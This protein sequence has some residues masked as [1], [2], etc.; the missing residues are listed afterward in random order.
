V[1]VVNAATAVEK[2]VFETSC[3]RELVDFVDPKE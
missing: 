1:H 3:S 2:K